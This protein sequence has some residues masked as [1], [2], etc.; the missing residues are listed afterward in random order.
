MERSCFYCFANCKQRLDMLFVQEPAD[1]SYNLIAKI[2][3][4]V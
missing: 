1:E 2:W 3:D 4:G